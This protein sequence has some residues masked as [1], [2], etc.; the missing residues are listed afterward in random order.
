MTRPGANGP[1]AD[2]QPVQI[3][4]AGGTRVWV[5]E[6]DTC[7]HCL[8]HIRRTRDGFDLPN[9]DPSFTWSAPAHDPDDIGTIE[10]PRE[11]VG[12][13]DRLHEPI[14]C[15]FPPDK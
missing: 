9:G 7:A 10:C 3:T 13:A 8:L 1:G 2:R 6:T 4:R 14:G 5:G 15:V 12:W 11:L